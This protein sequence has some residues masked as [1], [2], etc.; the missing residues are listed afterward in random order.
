MANLR[1]FR[2]RRLVAPAAVALIIAATLWL[3]LAT[4]AEAQSRDN[5]VD[6]NI[7][8]RPVDDD[9]DDAD[10]RQRRHREIAREAARRLEIRLGVMDLKNFRVQVNDD[11]DIDVTVYGEHSADAIRGALV[12]AGEL[13]VRPVIEEGQVWLDL[14]DELPDGVSMRSPS[15][16]FQSDRLF[17]Y[18]SS[19]SPLRRIVERVA[20]GSTMLTVFPHEQGWRTLRL[21]EALADASDIERVTIEKTPAG[22]PFVTLEFD[23]E[24]AQTT[25]AQAEADDVTHLAFV[26]DGEV[27]GLHRFSSRQF[28]DSLSLDPPAHLR[29][30]QARHRWAIQVAGRLASPIPVPLVE[31]QE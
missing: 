9:L 22:I 29:S 13:E 18:A 14:A 4:S 8:V 31:L 2:H 17:L 5:R 30:R 16:N 20:L 7:A 15:A 24:A 11:N 28:S 21:G 27:V 3:G 19:P 26:L 10:R 25:R 12:P 6:L 1:R 23:S